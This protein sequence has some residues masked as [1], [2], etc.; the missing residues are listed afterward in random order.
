MALTIRDAARSGQAGGD[1]GESSV[2]RAAAVKKPKSAKGTGKKTTA[3]AAPVS[4]KKAYP[5]VP[6]KPK[7][8]TPVRQLTVNAIGPGKITGVTCNGTE[9]FVEVKFSDSFVI[10]DGC[11]RVDGHVLH[12]YKTTDRIA[13]GNMTAHAIVGL[14]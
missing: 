13:L 8:A 3:K 7:K 9:I 2:I 10:A 11:I 12:N 1:V 4:V 14:S 6:P 5:Y